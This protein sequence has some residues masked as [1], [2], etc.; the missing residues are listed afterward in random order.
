MAAT[1]LII[2]WKAATDKPPLT[3]VVEP[4][5][6]LVG[7]P[8]TISL[9]SAY[10]HRLES[11]YSGLGA[12]SS[13]TEKDIVE[14]ID[15]SGSNEV[16]TK[17]PIESI[18]S[19]VAAIA[20]VDEATRKVVLAA[21]LP[22]DKLITVVNQ[23][24]K[25][26]NALKLHGSIKL[27]YKTFPVQKWQH[28]PFTEQ[29]AAVLFAFNETV[30]TFENVT[31]TIS[32]REKNGQDG[33]KIQGYPFNYV[34]TSETYAKFIVFPASKKAI[35]KT[36]AGEVTKKEDISYKIEKE[37]IDFQ[38]KKAN[39]SFFIDNKISFIGYF[40]DGK[41]NVV[42]PS[43]TV[44]DGEL[45]ASVECYG[46]GFL[47]YQTKGTV[48][49]YKAQHTV[50]NT[51]LFPSHSTLVGTIFAFDPDKVGIAATYDIPLAQPVST[52]IENMIEVYREV[53]VIGKDSYEMPDCTP[54]YPDGN[55]YTH[56][57]NSPTIPPMGEAYAVTKWFHETV[58]VRGS[59]LYHENAMPSWTTPVTYPDDF[60]GVKYKLNHQIPEQPT[61]E[62]SQ[63]I[64]DELNQ[65]KAKLI[66]KYGIV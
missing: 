61:A 48:Y 53:L 33:I 44:S 57:P 63:Q 9:Y 56:Y 30:K 49:D 62:I 6:V 23:K 38:G 37:R 40:F 43:F 36:N 11:P 54:P 28:N 16:T 24:L 42:N 46:V 7:D 45:V 60:I 12:K 39:A 2:D 21:G 41:H 59:V 34:I 13:K 10:K 58:S 52:N 66:E 27:T 5:P 20:L 19:A 15:L 64:I 31:F 4:S 17:F 3:V 8:L 65:A 51:G 47:T 1:T 32:A 35:V 22:L 26:D 18:V 50:D 14:V 25:I 55:T 29:G